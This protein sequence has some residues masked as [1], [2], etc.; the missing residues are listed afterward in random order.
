VGEAHR[1][2][3]AADFLEVGAGRRV[4]SRQ[5]GDSSDDISPDDTSPDD[6][7]PDDTSPDDRRGGSRGK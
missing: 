4:T 2:G 6:T 7:S 1:P 3:G 5:T